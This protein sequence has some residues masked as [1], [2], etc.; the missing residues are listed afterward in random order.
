MTSS[1]YWD[2]KREVFS[3]YSNNPNNVACVECGETDLQ[4]LELDHVNAGGEAYLKSIGCS[5]GYNYYLYLKRNNYPKS[6]HLQVLCRKCN[7][8]KEKD[9]NERDMDH[10]YINAPLI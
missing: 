9:N 3:H 4:K 6:P 5:A 1:N 2:I 7:L 10:A 8:N